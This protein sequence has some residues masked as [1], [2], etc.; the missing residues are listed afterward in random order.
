[1]VAFQA[2]LL[3]GRRGLYIACADRT[4]RLVVVQA[5][6][7]AA[8]AAAAAAG[9]HGQW[10]FSYVS[11]AAGGSFDGSLVTFYG[12]GAPFPQPAA[13]EVSVTAATADQG[14]GAYDECTDNP[15]CAHSV[16]R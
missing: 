15:T 7:G 1:M 6:M 2:D 5:T 9:G 16:C 4:V 14:T 10:N 11:M 3:D 8:A 13:A 12:I